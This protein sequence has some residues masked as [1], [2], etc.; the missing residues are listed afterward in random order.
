MKKSTLSVGFLSALVLA[1][2]VSVP[3]ATGQSIYIGPAA[4]GEAV[5]ILSTG[6][7][8][9]PLSNACPDCLGIIIG[10]ADLNDSSVVDRLRAMYHA[11]QPV[12]LTNATPADIQRF[13][14]ML[15]HQG[16]AQAP[17]V[18]QVDL[19]AFRKVPRP[20]GRFHFS[21]HLLLPRMATTFESEPLSKLIKKTKSKKIRKFL[22][23]RLAQLAAQQ[24][25][26]MASADATDLEALTH[27]FSAT[28][29]L[30]EP[31]SQGCT[32]QT[33]LICL[34][35]SYQF[36]SIVGSDQY[37]D[38]I[39]LINNVWAA[40]SFQNSADLY[41]VSQTA[42]YRVIPTTIS[43]YCGDCS[44]HYLTLPL[45]VWTNLAQNVPYEV[46]NP[47]LD[48]WSP[49]STMETTEEISSVS[50]TIGGSVGWNQMQGLNASISGS[51]T[52][53]NETIKQVPPIT[54]VSNPNFETAETK[55]TY[56]VNALSSQAE[57][58]D[59]VNQWIW[60][61]P[62]SGYA[63]SATHLTFGSSGVLYA[64]WDINFI[65]TEIYNQTSIPVN[66]TSSVPLPFGRTFSLQPPVVTGVSPSCVNSGDQFTIQ[67]TGFYP[68]LVQSVE[69]GGT[70]VSPQSVDTISD[71]EIKV[72][73]PDTFLCHS[74]GCPVEVVTT[75]AP[76]NTNFNIVISDFC[77]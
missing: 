28:P 65:F 57:A 16:F 7:V 49:G 54:I 6:Y 66:M 76:S 25:Q 58:I 52:I 24:Q 69:I 13:H 5:R 47:T 50:K 42:H 3:A 19:A 34:A 72:T 55:W 45:M 53:T 15:G 38:Q 30:P 39:Q 27:T 36:K 77:F 14:D 29:E 40:R 71:T 48:Q 20:D 70:P 74:P 62:F 73:A 33:N 17:E 12:A 11:G 22:K 8:L 1:S 63:P 61:I 64:K 37:G 10:P 59:P 75:Q 68:S 60:S 2:S 26:S 43:S 21:S 23:R 41:Y 46:S 18:G 44:P 32:D 67:G 51:V 35:D 56:D 4:S 9:Q 31:P